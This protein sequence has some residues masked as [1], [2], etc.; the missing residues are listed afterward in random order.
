M[1]KI[2]GEELP[3]ADWLRAQ[4]YSLGMADIELTRSLDIF[5]E[6]QIR[7]SILVSVPPLES[8]YLHLLG[9]SLPKI[10][11]GKFQPKSIL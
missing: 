9:M 4:N 10:I 1:V 6:V 8:I 11:P 3:I 5:E 2:M 7:G